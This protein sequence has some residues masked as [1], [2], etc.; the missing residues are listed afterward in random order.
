M[1][2]PFC[3]LIHKRCWQFQDLAAER[4]QLEQQKQDLEAILLTAKLQAAQ[5]LAGWN[6]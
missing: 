4:G 2:H 6:G 5:R 3:E 1:D